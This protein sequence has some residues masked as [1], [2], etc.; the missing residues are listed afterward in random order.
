MG[1]FGIDFLC[2]PEKRREAEQAVLAI[3][4]RYRDEEPSAAEVAKARKSILADQLNN[5]ATAR[6]RAS[7]IGR[8]WL[9]ARN[10]DLGSEYLG[11][12]GRVEASDLRRV[13]RQ[14]LDPSGLTVT[15]INPRGSLKTAP[16]M[17]ASGAPRRI[18]KFTLP[19]GLRVLV[20]EDR[21][22]PLVNAVA[23]FRGGLLAET[24]GTNGITSLAARTLV[25][26]TSTRTAEQINDEIE[27]VGGQIRADSGN[28]SFSVS[29]EVMSPDLRLGLDLLSDVLVRAAFP[30]NEIARE[31]EDQIAAIKAE[32]E[33]ITAVAKHAMRR[34]IFGFHP[35]GLRSSGT[36]ESVAALTREQLLAFRD[37]CVTASNGVLAVFGDVD[38]AAV[39]SLAEEL[40]GALPSGEL[41]MTGPPV[42]TPLPEPVEMVVNE[43]KQQAVLMVG[44]LGTD[45]LS[46]DRSALELIDTASS[47]M[48]SRFFH[49]IREELGLAYFVGAAQMMGFAPGIFTFYLGTGP[50]KADLV[51]KNFQ[52]EI[53]ALARDGLT[54]AELA[55][56]K[57]KIIGGEA[58]RNQSLEAFAHVVAADE[59]YGLGFDHY[60]RRA[61]EI[62]AVTAGDIHAV[63]RKYFLE[64]NRATVL[65]TPAA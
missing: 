44:F 10:P 48:A 46:P 17:T 13:V 29:V 42:A 51:R 33:Q 64:P 14:Y 65:V 53:D 24:P 57:K 5:L 26:G 36:E 56:A 63:A 35:Y 39:R 34:A 49:R 1:L 19:N 21:K 15:S 31:K 58:I 54:E 7:D 6:G 59:L 9:L 41:L 38:S 50:A 28:N 60:A 8:S 22:L 11:E 45:A 37:R 61:S 2:D 3:V 40:F 27:D 25:K 62:E 12:I 30:D 52:D 4:A 16:C 47:D 43:P 18:E 23:V 32:D 20:C 55:R